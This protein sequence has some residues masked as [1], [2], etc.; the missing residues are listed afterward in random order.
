VL[1]KVQ[2]LLSSHDAPIGGVSAGQE[3]LFPSQTS[4]VSQIPVLGRQTVPI[5]YGT[6]DNGGQ[7]AVLPVQD[8][9][10]VQVL[11]VNAQTVPAATNES[12][13][14]DPLA[15]L[16]TSVMSQLPALALQITDW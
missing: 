12:F 14:Q 10:D 4:V 6:F 1:F 11:A 5:V 9:F 3:M 7:A 2:L 15:A 16:H 8:E 13:G